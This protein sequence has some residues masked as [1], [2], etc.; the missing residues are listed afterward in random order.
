MR[1]LID[2][3]VLLWWMDAPAKL[4]SHARQLIADPANP[5]FVSSATLWELHLKAGL[6]RL[7]FPGT[8]VE[9]LEKDAM[10]ELPVTWAHAEIGRSLDFPHFDPF[11][12]ML[13]AQCAHDSLT[14]VTRDPRIIEKAP[15]PTIPA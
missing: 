8:I 6:G 3:H 14:L 4:S 15:V 2:S 9:W 7:R 10:I 11:D 12:R 5:V 1:L 13:V